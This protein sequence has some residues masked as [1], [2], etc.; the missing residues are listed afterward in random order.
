MAQ[1]D[2]FADAG[3]I[4]ARIQM[5]AP[6]FTLK[7]LGQNDVN[8]SDYRGKTVLLFFWTTWWTWCRKE[9][10]SLI[11]LHETYKNKNFVILAIDIREKYKTVKEYAGKRKIPFQIL[12]DTKGDVARQYGARGTPAHFFIGKDGNIK[13]GAMGYKNLNSRA[14]KNLILYMIDNPI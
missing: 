6:D 5:A 3:F 9:V 4:Q 7:D 11:R 2:P 13:G 12:L 8:L 14:G 10:P 1:K